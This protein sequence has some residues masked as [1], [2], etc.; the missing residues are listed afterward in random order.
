MVAVCAYYFNM[1]RRSAFYAQIVGRLC[2]SEGKIPLRLLTN[3][4]LTSRLLQQ[5]FEC[6]LVP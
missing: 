5:T 2:D 4:M 6:F 3:V 1:K